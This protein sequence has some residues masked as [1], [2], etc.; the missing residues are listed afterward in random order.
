MPTSTRVRVPRY[1]RFQPRSTQASRVGSSNRRQDTTPEI[2]LR[3]ALRAM[4]VRY[5]ANVKSLPGCP[6][7]VFA[8]HRLVLF[9]DGDFWHG[10]QWRRR[11]AR[12]ASGW[13]ADYWIA[14]IARNRQRDQEIDRALRQT[15]WHVIRVWESDVKRSPD[16]IARRVLRGMQSAPTAPPARSTARPRAGRSRREL[17]GGCT[18]AGGFRT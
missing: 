10:R 13:N 3:K 5:R 18:D 4:K 11:K 2:L 16:K 8:K 15:G 12:L 9:C 14:K 6:D 7:F 17:P 1:D